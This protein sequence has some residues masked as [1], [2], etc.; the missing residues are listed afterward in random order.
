[1]LWDYVNDKP[2]DRQEVGEARE[3]NSLL[4]LVKIRPRL[5]QVDLFL[6]C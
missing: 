3:R 6:A 4:Y 1:M 5:A 2:V